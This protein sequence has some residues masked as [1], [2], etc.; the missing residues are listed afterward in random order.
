MTIKQLQEILAEKP[1]DAEI[2]FTIQREI[3]KSELEKMSYPY[4]YDHEKAEYAGYDMG[5]SDNCLI[6]FIEPR[7]E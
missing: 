3:P 7:K 2:C 5:Y 1:E 6:I 4:P